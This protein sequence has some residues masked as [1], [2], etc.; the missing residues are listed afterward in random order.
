MFTKLLGTMGA[1]T[2]IA[3]ACVGPASATAGD[4]YTVG[5]QYGSVLRAEFR[6]NVDGSGFFWKTLGSGDCSKST[7]TTADYTASSMPDWNDALSWARDRV[8]CDT[9]IFQDTGLV[10]PLTGFVDYGDTGRTVASGL[11]NR[12]S[13]YQ[14][15]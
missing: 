15:S 6:Q 10:N 5:G 2:L 1:A 12:T 3:L 8:L 7:T 11:N 14:L 9:K 13:S 4:S